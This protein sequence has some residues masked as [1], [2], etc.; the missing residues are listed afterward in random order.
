VSKQLLEKS[1]HAN[2]FLYTAVKLSRGDESKRREV[3]NAL[4]CLHNEGEVD[5]IAQFMELHNEPDSKLDFVF[6]R[7]LF[8]KALP[9]LH[10]PVEQVMACVSHLVKEA[11]NDMA[12]NSVFTSFVDYCE[13]DSSR[14]E[15]ALELIKKDPDKWM[16]FIASTISAGTRL[17]FEGFLK[18]AIAL[19]NHDKLEIRRRA[20]F[21]LSRIKFPA[22]QEHLMTEV[23]DCING[24]V[25]RESDD[26]LLANTV[27]PIVM[28]LAITPLVPQCLDTMKTV[29]EKGSDRTIYNIAEA[30]ASSDNLPG[31]FYE[32][33]SPYMLKKFPSN[34]EATTMI[35]RCTVAIIE[36][37]GPA[38][39][40]DFLQ[41]YLIMNK[42]H[43][44][45]KPFQGFIYIALQNRALCQKV[46]TRWLLLGEPVLCDAVNTIVCASHDD[47][48]IL[49]VDQKEIDCNSTEQ[50]VFLAR[51]AI[52]YLF[53]K[54]IA[55]ASMIMSLILQTT[56]SDLTQH[57]S[58]LLFNPL[59]INYPGT[60]VVYYKKKIE[61][62]VQTEE[63]TNVLESW[64][65]YLKSLQSIEEVPE[66]HPST[67]EK[68]IYSRHFN[69]LLNE[70][71]KEA[72][73]G[74]IIELM[75]KSVILYGKKSVSYVPE[76]SGRLRRMEVPLSCFGAEIE[77]PRMGHI[78]PAGLS[79]M[80]RT[81]RAERWVENEVNY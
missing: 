79:F 10:A 36:R 7:Y 34:A 81:F 50:M 32:M 29:L 39:G 59:L 14:P 49:E 12:N 69:G 54:P 53:F 15:T 70:S 48:Y 55:A 13:T 58:S 80:L 27:W 26:L 31:L 74:S 46:C 20:V 19:T 56:D 43:V 76:Q 6:A 40:L 22:E 38:Q 72:L 41:S 11:G 68:L 51:K 63:L 52:G 30:F 65:S 60:L 64:D 44:S 18:E 77:Y 9:L 1:L 78:D 73:K 16:D 66:L 37:D 47:E 17:D 61:A 2:N 3:I 42:P 24:I 45:L 21:S 8:K 62:Q 28:L 67:E 33:V 57:L 4:V 75:G 25:T 23:L 35:D 5:L 71:Y